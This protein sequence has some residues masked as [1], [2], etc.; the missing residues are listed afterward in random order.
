ADLLQI[1]PALPQPA[2]ALD[3]TAPG[4]CPGPHRRGG[5]PVQARCAAGPDNLPRRPDR[6]RAAG[7]HGTAPRRL[8][9]SIGCHLS[10]RYRPHRPKRETA[11]E[12]LKVRTGMPGVELDRAAF[13]RRLR[14]RFYDPAFEAKE[15]EIEAI[16]ET[17]FQAYKENRKAPRTHKAGAGYADPDYDL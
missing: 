5:A 1:C 17:A 6:H 8:G 16:V 11:M 9:F 12:E 15:A 4:R 14:R 7:P 2:P 10:G 13:A 3:R